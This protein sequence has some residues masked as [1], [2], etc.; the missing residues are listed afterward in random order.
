MDGTRVKAVLVKGN[1]GYEL[2]MKAFH[3]KLI[4][5]RHLSAM[6][7]RFTRQWQPFLDK[8]LRELTRGKTL[9]K[10]CDLS[11]SV[12]SPQRNH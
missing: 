9:T 12:V 8:Y 1:V 6:L 2:L 5:Q 7:L 11:T 3:L 4:D 10:S